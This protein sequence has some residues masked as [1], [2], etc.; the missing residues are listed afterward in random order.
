MCRGF[1]VGCIKEPSRSDNKPL[2]FMPSA[3]DRSDIIDNNLEEEYSLGRVVGPL[4][5]SVIPQV[6]SNWLGIIPKGASGKWRPNADMSFPPG[7]SV[8]DGISKARCSLLYVGVQETIKGI[9]ARGQG[10]L[11]VK[12]DV[13]SAYWN[14]LVH[15]EDR[16]L[17]SFR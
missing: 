8:N 16:W 15:P 14:T 6:Y 17:V 9:V 5:P 11:M 7:S 13:K 1:T 12:V 2:K 4:D 10:T 3:L